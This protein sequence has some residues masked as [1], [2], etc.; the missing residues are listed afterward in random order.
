MDLKI[1]QVTSAHPRDDI[2]IYHKISKSLT[3]IGEVHLYVADGEGDDLE[4]KSIKIIDCGKK[5]SRF[6]RI[7]ITPIQIFKKLVNTKFDYYHFHDPEMIFVAF[8]LSLLGKKVIF[9]LHEDFPSQLLSK[10]YLNR[11]VSFFLSRIFYLLERVIFPFFYGIVSATP[12][13]ASNLTYLRNVVTIN[14]Y[15]FIDEF[16]RNDLN[17][18]SAQI[19]YAGQISSI[20]GIS[21]L[22]DSLDKVNIDGFKLNLCGQFSNKSFYEEISN[23]RNWNLVNYHGQVSREELKYIMANC[24]A[25]VVTFLPYPN[26]INSQPNKLFEYM[27]AGLPVICSD[28]KLWKLIVKDQC[29]YCINPLDPISIGKAIKK[30][31]SDKESMEKFSKAGMSNIINKYNWKIEENKLFD[32]YKES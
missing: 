17:F 27:S 13:I 7:L 2:R 23:H 26:H 29:G 4:S 1:C 20:R 6:K 15:P 31:L 12:S 30:L 32:L 8:S 25:G 21:E 28:F 24:S 19:L 9:D 10:P 18:D 22:M 16:A 5:N 14:N 3:K 11:G